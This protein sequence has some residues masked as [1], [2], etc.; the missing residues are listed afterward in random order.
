[1][2]EPKT[3]ERRFE[4]IRMMPCVSGGWSASVVSHKSARMALAVGSRMM[5][6]RIWIPS[7]RQGQVLLLKKT[8]G[9]G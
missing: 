2:V 3:T 9:K 7:N 1:M 5:L 8:L 6:G 4:C